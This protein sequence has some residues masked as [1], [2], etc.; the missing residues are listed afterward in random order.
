[1]LLTQ[2]RYFVALARTK[3]FGRAADECFVSQSTLSEGISKFETELGAKLVHRGRKFQELTPQGE[4]LLPWAKKLMVDE[5]TLREAAGEGA[6]L[7]GV[8]RIGVVPTGMT[9]AARL[10][11]LMEAA[12]PNAQVELITGLPSEE[13]ARRIIGYDLDAGI[14]YRVESFHEHLLT[15]N[16]GETT[17]R[18]VGS[19]DFL[20]DRS[21]IRAAEL[22]DYPLALLDP[23]MRGR[24]ILDEVMRSH[25]M[26][27]HPQV[28]TNSV[29][30]LVE[31]AATGRWCA[32]FPR[33]RPASEFIRHVPSADLIEPR[34][35]LP[36]MLALP[37][38]QPLAPL[39]L[40]LYEVAGG[41]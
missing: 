25:G 18:V 11:F 23:T 33:S 13:I 26:A 22:V 24:Q 10:A 9:D 40:A 38:D 32:L 6:A 2:I 28:E 35:T 36:M 5:R 15:V 21:Y 34:V 27:L 31:L 7:S 20:G 30:S 4:R 14:I 3:H 1:M 12:H 41:L 29:E 16:L 39:S 19:A 17:Y 37:M 8:V